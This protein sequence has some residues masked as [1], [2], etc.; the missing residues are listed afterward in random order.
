MFHGVFV[1]LSCVFV[2]DCENLCT[3]SKK[4]YYLNY[5]G[6]LYFHPV[7]VSSMSKWMIASVNLLQNSS[8]CS[9]VIDHDGISTKE[10][11][12]TLIDLQSQLQKESISNIQKNFPVQKA[13]VIK[14]SNESQTTLY[15]TA[16]S[17]TEALPFHVSYNQVVEVLTP[18]DFEKKCFA[19]IVHQG[20]NCPL[21]LHVYRDD[22]EQLVCGYLI[23]SGLF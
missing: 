22:N 17:S 16:N 4:T 3:L 8:F 19:F 2:M 18:N 12:K 1:D 15:D 20:N 5:A 7:Y 9:L 11:P 10:E 13:P 6:K 23:S 14:S 21:I